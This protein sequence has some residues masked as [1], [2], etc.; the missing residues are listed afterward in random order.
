VN[1]NQKILLKQ[2]KVAVG[3]IV[4]FNLTI[5]AKIIYIEMK[6]NFFIYLQSG[7]KKLFFGKMAIFFTDAGQEC[8]QSDGRT[9][10]H[11]K[12]SHYFVKPFPI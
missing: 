5:S 8:Y 2:F 3:K 11:K 9:F 1:S 4:I 12:C 6:T 10:W 7:Y